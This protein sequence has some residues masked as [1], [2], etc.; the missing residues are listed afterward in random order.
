[1][2]TGHPIIR[3]I[4]SENHPEYVVTRFARLDNYWWGTG[5]G[6]KSIFVG[7]DGQGMP[8]S[9]DP[10]AVIEHLSSQR[11]RWP[12]QCARCR[13]NVPARDDKMQIVLTAAYQQGIR[14]L[15]L[16]SVRALLEHAAKIP[17][18]PLR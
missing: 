6:L 1:M 2:S 12:L 17:R 16:R 3:V 18:P 8:E 7:P 15:P 13:F 9:S 14:T 10:E 4:C 11:T 5:R